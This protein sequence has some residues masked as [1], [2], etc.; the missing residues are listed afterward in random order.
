MNTKLKLLYLLLLCTPLYLHAQVTTVAGDY[1]IIDIG[2]NGHGD[3]TKNLILIHEIYNGT[4]LGMN[5]AVGT[6][7]AF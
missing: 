5:N 3:Y 6:I 4:L 1:K 7:T 2:F